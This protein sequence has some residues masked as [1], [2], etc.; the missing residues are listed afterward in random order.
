MAWAKNGTP[1]TLGSAGDT[2]TISDL[3]AYKF[4]M[5]LHHGIASSTIQGNITTDNN[6]NTD[7]AYR[8]SRDGAADFTGTSVTSINVSKSDASDVFQIAYAINLDSEEKLFICET[9]GQ[10][11][12]GAGTAPYRQEHVNK[13]DT[14]TNTG[15]FTRIDFENQGAG[16]YDTSS[17][18][19]ALGAKDTALTSVNIQDGTIF[20]ETDT[21]KSYI[22]NSSTSTWSQL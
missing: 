15:Q 22:W 21:N 20:E 7:Y 16:S 11:T 13:V 10:E 6:G 4:N 17:N 3:T 18:L 14:S 19:S 12:A 1:D 9:V 5:F 2:L 8:I